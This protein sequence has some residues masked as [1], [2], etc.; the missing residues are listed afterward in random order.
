MPKAAQTF[1][2]RVRSSQPAIL[3]ALGLT[4][5]ALVALHANVA[6]KVADTV[7]VQTQMPVSPVK[8]QHVSNSGTALPAVA[9]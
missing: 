5:L 1:S 3:T 4:G 2:R 6:P 7:A 8:L 9:R